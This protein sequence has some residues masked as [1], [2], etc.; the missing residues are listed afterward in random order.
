[1]WQVVSVIGAPKGSRIPFGRETLAGDGRTPLLYRITLHKWAGYYDP[2]F[3]QKTYVHASDED[4]QRGSAALGKIHK[5]RASLRAKIMALTCGFVG[6]LGGT[7]TPNLLIR[8]QMLYP[9][10]YERRDPA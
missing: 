3:T 9:L 4:L 8:S 7:R 2:A 6:A 5:I 1:M 10:S